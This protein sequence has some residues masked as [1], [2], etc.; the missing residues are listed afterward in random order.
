MFD[1]IADWYSGTCDI[2]AIIDT[3]AT[4]Q[5]RTLSEL[6]KKF[7]I[8]PMNFQESPQKETILKYTTASMMNSEKGNLVLTN[9]RLIF[10][11]LNT[12]PLVIPYK[13]LVAVEKYNY[14]IVIP[15]GLHTPPA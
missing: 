15:P 13:S 1:Q 11:P 4:I 9:K 5:N 3:I 8:P 2:G 14:T 7:A 6:E 10:V 12:A